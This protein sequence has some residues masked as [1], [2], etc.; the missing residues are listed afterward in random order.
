MEDIARATQMLKS[1]SIAIVSEGDKGVSK[2]VDDVIRLP[3]ED[4]ALFD[5]PV[6]A[7]GDG[8][9]GSEEQRFHIPRFPFFE[10]GG[11]L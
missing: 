3:A 8:E 4:E 10:G 1:P 2:L 7:S 11:T 9:V 5:R 6:V